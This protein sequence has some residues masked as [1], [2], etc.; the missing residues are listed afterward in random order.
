MKTRILS[1]CAAALM[2]TLSVGM[3]GQAGAQVV[4]GPV[5]ANV[6]IMHDAAGIPI[7]G[8]G[9]R[10]RAIY[11]YSP[12][13][14]PIYSFAKIYSGCFVPTWDFLDFYHGPKWPRGIHKKAH[15]KPYIKPGKPAPGAPGHGAI[16]QPGKPAAGHGGNNQPGKP[17][18]G[19]GGNNQPGKPAAGHGGNN[20]PGKPAAGHGGNN[21]PG[22]QGGPR[23]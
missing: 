17:A 18:A 7:W 9:T 4:V 12:E 19:H 8:Y 5:V 22:H 2:A 16:H 15:H 10:G 20:Q 1:V 11:A 13:G 6:Q 23:R 3:V 14:L 21:K